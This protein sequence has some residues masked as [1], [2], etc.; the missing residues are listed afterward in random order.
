MN[1]EQ[2]YKYSAKHIRRMKLFER[3]FLKPV[4]LALKD[5]I[6]PVTS[7]LRSKGIEAA[8]AGLDVV[9]INS[10]L[11][12]PLREIYRTVGLYFANKTIFDLRQSERKGSFGFNEEFISEILAFF[13]R[14]LL[15]KA[16]LPISETTKNQILT[17]ISEGVQN[18]WGA[19]RIAMALE[20]PDLLLWRARL[21]VRTEAN[22][23]MNYGQRLGESK[24]EW[25]SEKTWVAANDHRTRHSHRQVDDTTLDFDDR[26]MVPIYK[27]GKIRLQIGVDLM[28]GPGDVQASA[29]N[30]CNCR[31]TLAFAAKRDENGRLIRKK[32]AVFV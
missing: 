6:E 3:Q 14:Y 9:Q 12:P 26:F 25:E 22:K 21:I 27:G 4:I 17:I 5:Q 29:A 16:V 32:S 31:C 23:A 7:A 8:M 10:H 11:A 13:N 15:N 19:D 30:V 1:S 18:G 24:S 20:S 2:R 28:T